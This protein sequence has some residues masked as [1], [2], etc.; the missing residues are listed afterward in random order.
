M[1]CFPSFFESES[2]GLV[3]IEAMQ[4]ELPVVSTNWRGI[5]GV[6]KE[7]ENGFLAEIRNPQQVAEKLAQLIEDPGLRETMGRAGRKIFL[8]RFSS[9]VWISKMSDVFKFKDENDIISE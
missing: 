5:P 4:F 1:F 9:E 3:N 2:F 8:E 6:V 7:G